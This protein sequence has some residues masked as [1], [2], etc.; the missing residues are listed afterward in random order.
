MNPT[1]AA[2]AALLVFAIA[3][4]TPAA[5]NHVLGASLTGTPGTAAGANVDFTYLQLESGA[6]GGGHVRVDFGDGLTGCLRDPIGMTLPAG[7]YA[8]RL[9]PTYMA[10]S[11]TQWL[12]TFPYIVDHP[13]GG[14]VPNTRVRLSH[15]YLS[16]GPYEIRWQTCCIL[17][18]QAEPLEAGRF[19]A[20]A[21]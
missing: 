5:G 3:L 7:T 13:N 1:L 18:P 2:V 14:S 20:V 19:V 4:S 21:A 12:S 9:I 6:Q 17:V 8:G 16:P 15:D 11:S 10:C